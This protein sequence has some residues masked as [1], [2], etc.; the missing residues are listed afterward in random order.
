M[1]LHDLLY[2]LFQQK[3]KYLFKTFPKKKKKMIGCGLEDTVMYSVVSGVSVRKQSVNTAV[4]LR[5]VLE[6]RGRSDSELPHIPPPTTPPP[7]P[8]L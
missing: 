4:C 8:L 2:Q 5:E 3:Q 1:I 6:S 7:N